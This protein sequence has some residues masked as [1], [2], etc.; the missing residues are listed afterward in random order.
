MATTTAEQLELQVAREIAL[1]EKLNARFARELREVLKFANVRI[2]ALLEELRTK[3]GRLVATKATLG[4]V[5]GLRREIQRALT[6]AGFDAFA[7]AA[8]D[9][10]LDELAQT[11]LRGNAIAQRAFTLAKPDL[12]LLTA[13]KTVRFEEL[14]QV[15]A[16]T[17]LR[18]Q[19]IVLD[20]TLGL[21]DVEDLVADIAD[22]FDIT[23]R[24]ARTIYDTAIQIFSRQVDQL[25]ANGKPDELFYYAGPID[26]KTRPFCRERVGRVF[27]RKELEEADNG[28]L[29]NPLLTGGGFNCRH[30]PKRVSVLDEELLDLAKTGKRAPH[31]QEHLDLLK[32]EAA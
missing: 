4:R 10:P 22:D 2:R 31:V 18:L 21:R 9:A 29:P 11:V 13:F 24:Q 32:K 5:L 14:L 6:D 17:S 19:R 27:T 20:G 7:E 8:V 3:N 28:Q 26:T 15:S 25:H 16:A 1:I 12:T 23:D 30:Q